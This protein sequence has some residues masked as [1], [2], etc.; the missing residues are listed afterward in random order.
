MA[1]TPGLRNR[2]HDHVALDEIELYAEVLIAVA[3]TDHALSPAELDRALGLTTGPGASAP[4]AVSAEDVHPHGPPTGDPP[5]GE[6][7]APPRPRDPARPE[8]GARGEEPEETAP[9]D[10]GP[11]E[12]VSQGRHPDP[13]VPPRTGHRPATVVLPAHGTGSDTRPPH[14]RC[15]PFLPWYVRHT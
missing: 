8:E 4:P 7:Q 2:L 3:D 10:P 1:S 14:P 13:A 11:L 12:E 6:V 9:R 5:D 15:E